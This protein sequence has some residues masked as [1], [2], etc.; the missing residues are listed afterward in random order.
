[1]FLWQWLNWI[2]LNCCFLGRLSLGCQKS[3]WCREPYEWDFSA[4][5]VYHAIWPVSFTKMLR[6]S[7]PTCRPDMDAKVGKSGAQQFF[8]LPSAL[9]NAVCRCTLRS[10][11][12]QGIKHRHYLKAEF[13]SSQ[14]P[15]W[16]QSDVCNQPSASG[17]DVSEVHYHQNSLVTLIHV[18]RNRA[19]MD[20]IGCYKCLKSWT[21]ISLRE[22][23]P[24]GLFF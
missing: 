8:P 17:T 18:V 9:I 15:W 2:D 11:A 7:F 12:C 6:H 4:L 23:L 16:L 22:K 21:R 24:N 1:M 5:W 3:L 14:L 19:W 20:L 10:A 13:H